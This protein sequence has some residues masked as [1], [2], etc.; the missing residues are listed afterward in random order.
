MQMT[1]SAARRAFCIACLALGGLAGCDGGDAD[2]G[3]E[4][5]GEYPVAYVER[6]LTRDEL[7]AIVPDDL[8]DPALFRPG[9]RLLLKRR[10]APTAPVIDVAGRLFQPGERYDVRDVSASPAGDKL[11]FALRGPYIEDADEDDQ[12]T[13]NIWEYDIGTDQLRRV[14]T[15]NVVAEEGHDIMPAY[16]GDGRIVFSSTRQRASRAVLVDEGKPQFATLD[17]TGQREVFMLHVMD[18]DGTSI[19]QVS[20]NSSHDLWP[21]VLPDGRILFVRQVRTGNAITMNLY[22]VLPDGRELS[23]VFGTHSHDVVADGGA[24]LRIEFTRPSVLDD[25]RILVIERPYQTDRFGGSLAA[26]DISLFS[27]EDQP[28]LGGTAAGGIDTWDMASWPAE[29]RPSPAGRYLDA[30]PLGDNTGRLLVSWSACRVQA[31]RDP[32]APPPATPVEILPCVGRD[33]ANPAW[34]EAPPIY[35]VF[36]YDPANDTRLPVVVP[37]E[38]MMFSDLVV[39]VPRTAPA[40][41][42]DAPVDG[43]LY[44]QGVG[45]LDIRSVYDFDGSFGPLGSLFTSIAELADPAT[46]VAAQRPA[47]WLRIE[48]AVAIPDREVRDFDTDAFGVGGRGVGMREVIGY[49]PIEPDGSVRVKVPANVAFTLSITDDLGRRIAARH[50][51]WLQ[52]APGEERECAGCHVAT[53]TLPHGRND[54]GVAVLHAG[55]TGGAPYP[56][57]QATLV[58]DAGETMAQLRTRLDPDALW[59]SMD[60]LYSDVWTDPLVRAP[61]ADQARRYADLATPAPASA[62]CQAEWRALC[63]STIHYETHIH[64]MWS[65]PRPVMTVDGPIDARCDSCHSNRDAMDQSR[66]PA[67][68]LDLGEGY[69]GEVALH[70]TAYRE[71]LATDAVQVL[72]DGALVDQLVQ[73]VDGSGNPLYVVDENGVPVLDENN[74]QIPLM[75]TV[76]VQ[77]PLVVGSARASVSFFPLFAA[78]GAHAGWLSD[79]ELRLLAEWVDIGAQYYNDPFT[80]PLD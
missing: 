54:S 65:L 64:P 61:D 66:V 40:V 39:A 26:I 67:A 41:I 31:A 9:A 59:L 2:S 19:R 25:G 42:N 11:L 6:A 38:G 72:E 30:V 13:W 71:L 60:L 51:A 37:R 8:R 52:V 28:L 15:S 57:T 24:N 3:V 16:L 29:G 47:R 5:T 77:A 17:D 48:K 50:T 10:A 74:E 76:P 49:A 62:D 56:N 68:Q 55:A 7:G 78:G 73:A 20:N 69:S 32:A 27:D 18:A 4:I 35:G 43:I 22:R 14:I 23:P 58:A 75:V 34:E 80:A 63:R 1:I 53:S 45:I 70:M 44:E 36:V 12:P 79:A 21:T 33:L 46:A